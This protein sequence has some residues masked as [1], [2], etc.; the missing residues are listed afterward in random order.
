MKRLFPLFFLAVTCLASHARTIIVGNADE[1]KKAN[2]EARPGDIIVLKNGRWNDIIMKLDCHGTVEQPITFKAETPGK[3]I[4][5]GHSQLKFGGDYITVDGLLFTEGYAGDDAVVDFRINNDKLANHCR[6]TN[7]VINDFNNP[8]RMQENYWISLYGKN[9]RVDHC[10]FR[11]K[12]NMGVMIAVILDDDRSR[13]N[14][15]S[16]DHNYF[17]HR[18]PLASNSGEIIRVGVSQHCEF[19]SNTQIIDNFFEHCDGETEIVSIK[20]CSNVIR[21]NVF[22]ECQGGVVLRHG[23]FNTV[24]NNVFLGNGKAGT[25]GV[26]II[27]KGQWVVNNLFYNCR[28]IDFRSPLSVMNGVPNSPAFRYVPVTDAVV[29]N[30][31]FYNCSSISFCEG[32][33]TERSVPPSNVFLVKNIF[34]NKS[35]SVIYRAFDD[36]GGFAFAGNEVSRSIPQGLTSGFNKLEL[37]I[38]KNGNQPI[39]V[40]ASTKSTA[41][42]DS[43]QEAAK[44]RLGHVLPPAAGFT[45]LALL[46]QL[47]ANAY[48]Q[49]GATWFPKKELIPASPAL[50]IPCANA[51]DVHNAL[52]QN[53]P[54][55]IQLT[56]RE[57]SLDKP[58]TISSRV[59]F[60]SASKSPV[61][62]SSGN[63]LAV[64]LI[65]GN[66]HLTLS[67][68]AIDGSNVQA[69][70]FIC[71]D[72]SGSSNHFNLVVSNC[73]LSKLDR[74]KGCLDI[75]HCYKY[76]VADSLIIRN[77]QFADNKCNGFMMDDEKDNKGYY[78]AEKIVIDNNKFSGVNG[79]LLSVYRGGNDESTMGPNLSFRNNK[80]SDCNTA[81]G[82]SLVQLV[83]VQATQIAANKFS[84][85][86]T[87][88]SLVTYA[89]TVRARHTF[90]NNM[91]EQCGGITADGF[92]TS[93]N[94]T[95]RDQVSQE[96]QK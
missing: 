94:N 24:E 69:Q 76:M 75:Y 91:L 79:V 15:H 38:Q 64:F 45:N 13:S 67:G 3:V 93:S 31:T 33:D 57:Y 84:K 78:N 86:N 83:G 71:N 4:I 50:T 55:I 82:E 70:H 96:S 48:G 61:H 89:D 23:N 8:Q 88:H 37:G 41:L 46:H 7:S 10:S 66:G 85:C 17:G 58:F 62:I 59:I 1:L 35:D 6:L 14:F 40:S 9:N 72:S 53:R 36:I 26:R 43:L 18:P 16:L 68:L 21:N 44:K 65:K 2:G 39:P 51:T 11:D 47:E 27:N 56:A 12:K 20:S 28:G 81:N 87:G 32:S 49:T 25:G 19:N 73:N 30:N 5:A 29:A 22:K 90:E 77:S 74:A 42:P 60:T 34:Y 63:Q 80:V 95:V 54:M 52:S 92:V